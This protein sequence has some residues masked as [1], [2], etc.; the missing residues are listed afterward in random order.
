MP[1]ERKFYDL[2]RC[3]LCGECLSK[4]P[5]MRL[6]IEQARKEKQKINKG[7]ITESVSR[8][9]TSCFDCDFFCPNQANPCETIMDTWWREY[10]QS[11]LKERARYFL[12]IE[13]ENFRSF[14]AERFP[15]DE[16]QLLI[17]WDD[18][19]PAEEFIY[20]GCN[21][22]ASPYLTMTGLLPKLPIR[23]GLDWCC[24][25]MLFRMGLYDL[26]RE[27]GL[28]MQRRFAEMG[29][30][31]IFMMCT[32]GTMIFSKMLPEKFGIK[33]DIE[34]TPLVRYLWE[35]I[36][37]G[38][39]KI[40]N[41]LDM[42]AVIQDS[43]YSKFLGQEYVEM[44]RKIL[45]RIGVRVKEMP[46]S[47]ERMVCCG[48]GAGFSIKSNYHPYH[49]ARST[50]KRLNEAKKAGADIICGYCAGCVQ[51]LSTG[52]VGWPGAPEVYH[53]LEL[54]QMAAGEKPERRIK[55][56]ARAMLLGTLRNQTPKL[57]SGVRFFP[58]IK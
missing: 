21:V 24:G 26:F 25:E 32:A 22:C 40:T 29:A 17:K 18:A 34:F 5:E 11:G 56:R 43:C 35:Q 39:I 9:C 14:A 3:K 15:E 53:L 47:R 12:P 8:A 19:S 23:G 58:K 49:M 4:C 45:E 27:N 55:Q 30:K 33:F 51:M 48:I 46:R 13:K 42:T 37:S 50:F 2:E 6:P 16:K 31:R 7:D 10:R 36:E 44:P 54:V 28:K 52:G 20:P 57:I 38:G 1:D 41:K